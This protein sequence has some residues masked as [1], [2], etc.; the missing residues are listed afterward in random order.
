MIYKYNYINIFLLFRAYRAPELLFGANSYGP[1]VDIWS[2]GCI[3]A[4]LFYGSPIFPGQSD[5]D[6]LIKI[7]QVLGTPS[8]KSMK[9]NKIKIKLKEENW[10]NC[11]KLEGYVQFENFKGVSFKEVIYYFVII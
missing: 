11:T 10:P 2:V 3:M 9:K 1:K 4:E 6:Q 7:F 5:I 8:V